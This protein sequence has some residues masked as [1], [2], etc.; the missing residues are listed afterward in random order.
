MR[1][2]VIGGGLE[3]TLVNLVYYRN[4]LLNSS[5][6]VHLREK[7]GEHMPTNI[8][9]AILNRSRTL[10]PFSHYFRPPV[11]SA[12]RALRQTLPLLITGH[13]CHR[14]GHNHVSPQPRSAQSDGGGGSFKHQNTLRVNKQNEIHGTI[15]YFKRPTKLPNIQ[16]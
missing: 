11:K 7:W 8:P 9:V 15:L 5:W 13:S 16:S 3:F 12:A 10:P 14:R 4:T 6:V 2:Y 1:V